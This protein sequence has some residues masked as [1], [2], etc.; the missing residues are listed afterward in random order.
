MSQLIDKNIITNPS[1]EDL[2]IDL[3]VKIEFFIDIFTQ[4]ATA[5]NKPINKKL[6]DELKNKIIKC[7]ELEDQQ[8]K[9]K[10]Y[11]KREELFLEMSVNNNDKK[12]NP[13][14]RKKM[15]VENIEKKICCGENCVIF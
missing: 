14:Q 4:F 9:Y 8:I 5:L 12:R 10:L 13:T 2:Y 3:I 6:L 11:K 7:D 1:I 15:V